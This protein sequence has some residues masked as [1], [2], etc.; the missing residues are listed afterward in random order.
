MG[1]R[2]MELTGSWLC[3]MGIPLDS[4]SLVFCF[5][6][7]GLHG[8]EGRQMIYFVLG[9]LIYALIAV[10]PIMVMAKAFGSP[11]YGFFS[12]FL[13]LILS[14]LATAFLCLGLPDRTLWPIFLSFVTLIFSLKFCL[15]TR[16]FA[17]LVITTLY[18]VFGIF[19][20]FLL[21][22]FFGV[23]PSLLSV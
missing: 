20:L 7:W 6:L 19:L 16:F 12:C 2:F 13:S 17:S 3:R 22:W 15:G 1:F 10:Y 8:A 9:F 18:N 11:N 14:T 23:E 5:M 21:Y 4:N